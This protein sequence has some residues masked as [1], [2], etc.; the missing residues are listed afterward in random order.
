[1]K[2]KK[3]KKEDP[4]PSQTSV[5]AEE[6]VSSV[7]EL[8]G[9]AGET[10]KK[11]RRRN[12]RK[13]K[14]GVAVEGDSDGLDVKSTYD[15]LYDILPLGGQTSRVSNLEVDADSAGDTCI[16][17]LSDTEFDKSFIEFVQRLDRIGRENVMQRGRPKL[18]PNLEESWLTRLRGDLL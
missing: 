14:T 10:K 1:M 13:K 18:M 3:K 11:K 4:T 17:K 9:E 8:P 7:E 12:K 16:S 15:E 6:D 2:T 5:I